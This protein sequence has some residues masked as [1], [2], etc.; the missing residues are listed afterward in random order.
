MFISEPIIDFSVFDG[1]VPFRAFDAVVAL[2]SA[3]IMLL[4]VLTGL[5][6]GTARAASL[7]PSL[8]RP[9]TI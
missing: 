3:G 1:A 8:R 9:R 4:A 5:G 7:T 6:A 2:V